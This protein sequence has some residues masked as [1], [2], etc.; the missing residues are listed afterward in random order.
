MASGNTLCIFLPQDATFPAS[1]YAT[2][3]LRNTHPVLDFDGST[4]EEAYFEGHLPNNYAGGGLTVDLYIS[5]SSATS[6]NSRWQA[7]FERQNAG[8][9]D[10]DADSFSGTFQSAGGVP[11]GTSGI[12]TKVSIALSNAQIDSLAANEPFRLKIRRDADGTSGTDDV[13]TDAE[14]HRVVIRET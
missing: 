13:T 11:N 8:G 9:S 4:D 2:P 5:F 14:L 12:T 10:L 1:N 6:G 3:D 7:D